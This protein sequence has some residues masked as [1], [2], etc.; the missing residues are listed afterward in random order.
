MENKR[1]RIALRTTAILM[2]V[3]FAAISL[4]ACSYNAT[5]PMHNTNCT[6]TGNQKY[7]DGG[8]RHWAEYQCP[9]MQ[10]ERAHTFWVQC[11]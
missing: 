10:S 1:V 8:Q 11:D 7:T 4:F 6:G 5:C 2:L 9:G 3:S